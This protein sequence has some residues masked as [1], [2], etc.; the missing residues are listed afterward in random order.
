MRRDFSCDLVLFVCSLFKAFS[1][2]NACSRLLTVF[3]VATPFLTSTYVFAGSNRMPTTSNMS[4]MARF[5][6]TIRSMA[7]QTC[8]WSFSRSANGVEESECTSGCLFLVNEK[9][10]LHFGKAMSFL[11][12]L[13]T[14][15]DA[16]MRCSANQSAY[17]FS[18]LSSFRLVGF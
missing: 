7:I 2:L 18:G 13:S 12:L 6:N 15:N 3:I 9:A 16:I 11:V 4:C 1:P 14:D 8:E 10:S 5:S 17:K